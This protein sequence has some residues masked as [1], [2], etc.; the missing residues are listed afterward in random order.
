MVPFEMKRDIGP[1]RKM[2]VIPDR[3]GVHLSIV[4]VPEG[5]AA[6]RLLGVCDPVIAVDQQPLRELRWVV[7]GFD[8]T[9]V[10]VGLLGGAGSGHH[11]YRGSVPGEHPGAEDVHLAAQRCACIHAHAGEGGTR[12]T[13]PWDWGGG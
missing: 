7:I 9:A 11:G 8:E 5:S 12:F 3:G 10:P 13:R 2:E 6:V 4:K 1:G